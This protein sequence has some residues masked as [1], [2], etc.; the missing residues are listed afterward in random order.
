MRSLKKLLASKIGILIFSALMGLGLA[1]LFKMSCD[2]KSCIVY[3]APDFSNIKIVKV[4]GK[5]Y[6]VSEKFVECDDKKEKI[7]L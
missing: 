6:K 5:C 3:K 2:S 4:N 7:Y 1:G